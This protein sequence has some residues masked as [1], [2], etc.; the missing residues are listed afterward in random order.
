MFTNQNRDSRSGSI[1]GVLFPE[2]VSEYLTQYFD[3][4]Y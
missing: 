4:A 3:L 2:R 1:D